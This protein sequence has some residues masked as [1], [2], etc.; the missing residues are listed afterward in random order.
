[1]VEPWLRGTL[2]EVNAVQLR[3]A[4]GEGQRGGGAVDGQH[5]DVGKV[6]REVRKEKGL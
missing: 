4:G 3:E 5:R 2:M 6:V 1:M